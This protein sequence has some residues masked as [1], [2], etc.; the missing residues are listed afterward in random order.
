MNEMLGAGIKKGILEYAKG[1]F[2]SGYNTLRNE[3]LQLLFISIR[4]IRQWQ[5]SYGNPTTILYPKAKSATVNRI[6]KVTNP[7]KNLLLNCFTTFIR[8]SMAPR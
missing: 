1:N 8:F 6:R 4:V 3:K 7:K 2:R 5:R